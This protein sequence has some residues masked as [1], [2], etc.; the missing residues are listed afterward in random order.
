MSLESLIEATLAG[1][2]Y[3]LVDMSMSV[4]SGLLRV[5]I[6]KPEGITLDDCTLVSNHLSNWLVVENIEYERLEVSSPGMDRPLKKPAD[7]QRFMGEQVQVK[8]RVA[9]AGQRRFVGALRSASDTQIELDVDGQ[10]IKFDIANIDV[11]RL[12]PNL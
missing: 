4:K 9:L 11:A 1:L 10:T 2:G 8:L 6:D 3:E 7:Y 12:V 5:F